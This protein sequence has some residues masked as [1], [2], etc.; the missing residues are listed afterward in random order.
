M[1][2]NSVVVG[3]VNDTPFYQSY[4][5][6]AAHDGA[7]FNCHPDDYDSLDCITVD[8]KKTKI[9]AVV[10]TGYVE[11]ESVWEPEMGMWWCT[12]GRIIEADTS[13]LNDSK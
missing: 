12:C 7:C 2:K 8:G 10:P 9:I 3:E 13:R 5:A 6:A 1:N 11:L 4:E